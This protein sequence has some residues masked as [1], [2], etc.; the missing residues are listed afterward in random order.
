MKGFSYCY[1]YYNRDKNEQ[2]NKAKDLVK[3]MT[4]K[5]AKFLSLWLQHG[6]GT[7]AALEAYDTDNEASAAQIA[8]ENLRKLENPMKLYLENKGIS[9]HHL[10]DVLIEALGA[11]KI[12]GTGDNFIEIPDHKI[13]LDAVDR[14]SEW[15]GVKQE[16]GANVAVQVNFNEVT[17]KDKEEF[18]I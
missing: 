6:N 2:K 17:S 10:T 1:K 3:S 16:K 13:R 5:Q 7:K 12:H 14:L 9:I 4:P 8:F 18:N 15:L 11:Q